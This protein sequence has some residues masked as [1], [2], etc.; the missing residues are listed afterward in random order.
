MAY[1]KYVLADRTNN[2]TE[3]LHLLFV[4]SKHKK[5]DC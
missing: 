2:F 1:G 5:E 4:G 3:Q